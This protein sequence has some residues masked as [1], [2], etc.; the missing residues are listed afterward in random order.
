MRIA[1]INTEDGIKTVISIGGAFLDLGEIIGSPMDDPGRSFYGTVM[2]NTEKINSFISEGQFSAVTDHVPTSYLLP[3]PY[4]NQIRDFYAFEGHVKA[5]RA[6][7]G[8]EMVPEWYEFPA[9]YYSGNSSLYAS[10]HDIPYPSF[11]S[12]LDFELEVAAIIGREGKNIPVGEAWSHIFGFVLMNDWSA[13][14]QQRKE[15][16]IGL[17]PSKS[18]D[19]ATS[20]GRYVIT[21]DE[22]EKHLDADRRIDCSVQASVNGN[23]FV[24][25]NLKDMHW[26]FQEMISWA[27]NE[28]MLKPGDIIMSG[29]VSGGCILER[30]PENGGWLKIGDQVSFHSDILGDLVTRIVGRS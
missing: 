2:K 30:G 21:A 13:R 12:E 1:R 27:S 20:M 18:K 24:E 10:D 14:D 8:L 15:M 28:T 22:M 23:L 6:R 19:F 17:G 9:Y 25:G 16:K 7:R 4:V 5:A 11:S 26:T 3:M 29:T